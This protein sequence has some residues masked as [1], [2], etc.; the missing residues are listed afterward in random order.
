MEKL[1]EIKKKVRAKRPNFTR[2]DS[3]KKKKLKTKWRKPKG[4]QNKMRLSRKG[5]KSIVK[6]GYKSPAV[7][8][9]MELN[10]LKKIQVKNVSD[11][12]KVDSKKECATIANVGLKKKIDIVKEAIKRKIIII[13]VKDPQDFLKKA[14]E[15]LNRRK[16]KKKSQEMKKK[17]R[18]KEKEELAK[19]EKER[20]KEEEKKLDEDEKQK[21]EKKEREKLLI[22]R[23]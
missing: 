17:E 7:V 15:T 20:E 22:K 11:L 6:V 3:H 16:E 5:Y 18:E 14:E 23:Q 19:K 10:G 4:H 13:N 1:V 8:A 2:T 21:E 9:G 12:E